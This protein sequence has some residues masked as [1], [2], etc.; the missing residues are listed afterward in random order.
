[1]TEQGQFVCPFCTESFGTKAELNHHW[2]VTPLCMRNRYANNPLQSK[3]GM[4][5]GI[6]NIPGEP[7]LMRIRSAGCDHPENLREPLYPDLSGT[8][9]QIGYRCGHCYTEVYNNG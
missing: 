2:L 7:T 5:T 4:A 3:Y 1:M 8:S 6:E 9:P